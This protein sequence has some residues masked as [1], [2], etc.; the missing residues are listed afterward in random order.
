MDCIQCGEKLVDTAN[1]C[2]SCGN[3]SVQ[4]SKDNHLTTL[5]KLKAYIGKNDYKYIDRLRLEYG[6]ARKVSWN[7]AAFFLLTFW[8]GYRKMYVLVVGINVVWL[9]TDVYLYS[10]GITDGGTDFLLSLIT[11]MLVGLYGNYFYYKKA[12]K[13]IE[14]LPSERSPA[15]LNKIQKAGGTSVIGVVIAIAL[16]MGSSYVSTFYLYPALVTEKI[17]FG[18]SVSGGFG[19]FSQNTFQKGE[20]TFYSFDFS[21][22]KGGEFEVVIEQVNGNTH[23]LYEKFNEAAPPHW[24]SFFSEFEM[25][26]ESGNYVMKI[27]MEDEVIASGKFTVE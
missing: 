18:I 1:Y 22:G 16:T 24:H 17:E 9:L 27:M 23:S 14:K 5:E 4:D 19:T 3:G 7:W 25:P 21:R 13:H 26:N 8:A 2:G 11:A 20:I 15:N 10:N 6:E 12:T